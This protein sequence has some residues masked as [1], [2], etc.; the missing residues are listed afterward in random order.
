MPSPTFAHSSSLVGWLTNE[1]SHGASGPFIAN[2]HADDSPVLHCSS[3][4]SNRNWVGFLPAATFRGQVDAVPGIEL[5]HRLKADGISVPVIYM[6]GNEDPAVRNAAV[7]SA[8]RQNLP[9]AI[10]SWR[11]SIVR[12]YESE[13]GSKAENVPIVSRCLREAAANIHREILHKALQH[14]PEY[15]CN[16]VGSIRTLASLRTVAYD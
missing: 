11:T 3:V 5:R 8:P 10:P 12:P 16:P 9:E 7:G 14:A 4:R 13:L 2:T 6:T 15:L 1:A